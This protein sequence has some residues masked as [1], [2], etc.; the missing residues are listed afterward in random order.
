MLT[1]SADEDHVLAAFK[2]GAQAY[3][4]NGVAKQEL[5]DILHTVQ[6]GEGYITPTLAASLLSEMISATQDKRPQSVDIGELT[7]RERQIL[8]LVAIGNSNKE[9]GHQLHLTEKTIKH[10]VTKLLQKL[11]VRNRVE[12][13][14]LAQRGVWPEQGRRKGV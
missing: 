6:A 1:V 14:I 7:E 13:A 8:E 11:H 12:A 9:I 2:A 5:I 10:Y 3:V 4:L